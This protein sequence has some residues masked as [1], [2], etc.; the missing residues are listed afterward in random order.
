L[1]VVPSSE[2]A[3]CVNELEL[4]V[5]QTV[6]PE[7]TITSLGVNWKSVMLIMVSLGSQ[8]TPGRAEEAWPEAGRTTSRANSASEN[9]FPISIA[10]TILL[11]TRIS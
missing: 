1:K 2:V 7:R 11:S 5:Q 10:A 6:P 4:F 9:P 3:V 8:T